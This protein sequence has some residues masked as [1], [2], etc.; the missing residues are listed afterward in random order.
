MDEI[1]EIAFELKKNG[2]VFIPRWQQGQPAHVI[3]NSIGSIMKMDSISPGAKIPTVQTLIP[4]RVHESNKHRYSGV[5]GLAEF[6]LHTDLA[7]WSRPPRLLFLRCIKGSTSVHTKLL[8]SSILFSILGT[9]RIR[10]AVFCTRQSA[11][12]STRCLQQLVFKAGIVEGFRWDSMFLVPMNNIAREIAL[13]IRHMVWD[14]PTEKRVALATPG[15]TLILD[16]WRMLHGRGCVD[17]SSIDRRLERVYLSKLKN[18][19]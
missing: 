13:A 19:Y 12:R 5:F 18:E 2:Y 7:N 1:R 10:Q 6:P 3:A 16:N 9:E 15:D 14:E 4:Q 11:T 8:P 17:E